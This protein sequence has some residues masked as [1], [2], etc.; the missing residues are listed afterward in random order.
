MAARSSVD[1]ATCSKY[2]I[3]QTAST[4]YL[5]ACLN[6]LLCTAPFRKYLTRVLNYVHCKRPPGYFDA[7]YSD[8]M[9]PLDLL[10]HVLYKQVCIGEPTLS[11]VIKADVDAKLAASVGLDP[12]KGSNPQAFLVVD[13][14]FIFFGI[15]VNHVSLLW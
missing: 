4:C 11:R 7:E 2:A 9:P 8:Q 10:L 14:K 5:C 1:L 15:E 12:A 13:V 3:L 6:V